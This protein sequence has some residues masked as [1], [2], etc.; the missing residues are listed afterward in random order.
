MEDI[1]KMQEYIDLIDEQIQLEEQEEYA[2]DGEEY[3]QSQIRE[4]QFKEI[5]EILEKHEKIIDELVGTHVLLQDRKGSKA[6]LALLDAI[7]KFKPPSTFTP[8][9]I[10]LV[11][12]IRRKLGAE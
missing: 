2:G 9:T 11:M 3:R 4:F 6:E 5:K 8:E 1:K 10:K 7:I 12:S